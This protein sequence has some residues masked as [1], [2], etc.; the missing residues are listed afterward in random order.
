MD[1]Q[2]REY[3]GKKILI[4]GANSETIPLV[5]KAKEMGICTIVT[6][7]NPN[8]PAKKHA[9]I[10]Y[11]ID[12]M[13]VDGL[14]EMCKKE[15]VDGILVGVADRLVA[16]YQKVCEQLN[17]PCYG[18]EEQVDLFTDKR[19]FNNLCDEHD[20]PTIPNYK[21]SKNP[22]NEELDGLAFPVFVKPVDGNSGKGMS[23]CH[24]R[25]E[26]QPAIFKAITNSKS[27]TFLVEK[28]MDCEDMFIYYTF[29]DG[30]VMVSAMGD[31]Y[32]S[33][34]QGDL[35][36]VC[37][38]A[39]YPSQHADIYYK[40]LHRKMLMLFRELDMRNGILMIS[41][42]I[43]NDDLFV[44][45]PGFR[46]QGEAPNI[47]IE[48]VCGYDQKAMLIEFALRGDM[49]RLELSELPNYTFD[50]KYTSTLWVLSKT[51]T[52]G[53]ISGI[54]EAQLD[55]QVHKVV[56]RLF[57]GDVISESMIGTEAQVVARLYLVTD[58]EDSLNSSIDYY[59]R[60]LR[61]INDQGH[62]ML[63]SGLSGAGSITRNY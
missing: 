14:V 61:V 60:T 3:G 22:T 49:G 18:T 24:N 30:E 21:V 27:E 4:M 59:A 25:D 26:V 63:L 37:I 16:P 28:Y 44:Y 1:V 50:G 46:L 47:P 33:K 58:T 42:F 43:E 13:D 19:K 11:N 36:K 41:A 15:N 40:K 10:P 57:A 5:E 48:A 38:G 8:A 53:H 35:G 29:R 45:D 52:I 56:Q 23:I 17:L 2:M 9:D 51:G 31:R 20:I 7:N 62:D 55:K 34:E 39:K 6:D 32:T 12:G 54:E